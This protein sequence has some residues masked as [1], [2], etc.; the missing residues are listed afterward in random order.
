MIN[1]LYMSEKIVDI[2]YII[3]LQHFPLMRLKYSFQVFYRSN[4]ETFLTYQVKGVSILHGKSSITQ[5]YKFLILSYGWLKPIKCKS[6]LRA[7]ANSSEDEYSSAL[8]PPAWRR[9]V[10]I[11]KR[12]YIK[13]YKNLVH[14]LIKPLF[15]FI[16]LVPTKWDCLKLNAGIKCGLFIMCI[17]I[18]FLFYFWNK[19]CHFKSFG[20]YR[21][22][23]SIFLKNHL[24]SFPIIFK[25]IVATVQRITK[26]AQWFPFKKIVLGI[27]DQWTF[28]TRSR[29]IW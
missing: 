13:E 27:L 20:I 28:I 9:Y 12:I 8:W 18:L 17:L 22:N 1:K 6:T 24:H 21:K 16:F 25:K 5:C 15:S 10:T 23:P 19:F 26:E 14:F 3:Y 7:W 11:S 2:H 4:F 29:H